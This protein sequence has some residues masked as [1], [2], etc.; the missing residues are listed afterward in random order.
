MS[1]GRKVIPPAPLARPEWEDISGKP[2]LQR[3]NVTGG[4]RTRIP[5]NE[6]ANQQPIVPDITIDYSPLCLSIRGPAMKHCLLMLPFVLSA[7]ALTPGAGCVTVQ[8]ASLKITDASGNTKFSQAPDTINYC[9][10]S[11]SASSA[12]PK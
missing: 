1:L 7:C 2:H 3:S 10:P 8:T 9:P 11:V 6:G 4:L 5:K 12:A